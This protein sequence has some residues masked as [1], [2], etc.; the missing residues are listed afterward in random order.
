MPGRAGRRRIRA[1]LRIAVRARKGG[2]P[3][4]GTGRAGSSGSAGG[5]SG[6]GLAGLPGPGFA[7]DAGD[8]HAI[9]ARPI[10]RVARI[11][12]RGAVRERQTPMLMIDPAA[13]LVLAASAAALAI[14]PLVRGGGS[15]RHAAPSRPVG[16]RLARVPVDR[17]GT[18]RAPR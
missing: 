7:G 17:R 3:R 6:L 8:L 1:V 12:R 5:R 15:S 14:V 10:R 11:R 16:S 18:T 2:A 13:V 9:A 4:F